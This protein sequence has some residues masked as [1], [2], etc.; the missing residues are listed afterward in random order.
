MFKHFRRGRGRLSLPLDEPALA[1]PSSRKQKKR[2]RNVK[3]LSVF[4]VAVTIMA[5]G[6]MATKSS[7]L[8]G[9][10]QS[11]WDGTV[12]Q[13]QL[14]NLSL[15]SASRNAAGARRFRVFMPA[16]APHLSLCKSVM[17]SVALGYPL[18]VLLNWKG[19]FN[20]PEWH[21]AGSHIAKLESLHA[22]IEALLA[23]P[24]GVAHDDDLAV[25]VDAY[26]VWFQLPPS[27]LIRRYHQLNREAD[28]RVRKE[29]EATWGEHT[30]FPIPPPKHNILVTAAK[31][32]H[33]GPQSGSDPHY[34]HWPKSP[35]PEFMYGP[36]TD[37][38]AGPLLDA[39]RKYK[40]VRPR[41]V[42][43]GM[44]MGTM[45][46]LRAALSRGK[47]KIAEAERTG[48]QLW[49]DQA[50]FGDVMGDQ[51]LWREWMR[52]LGSTWDGAVAESA[53]SSLHR[54]VRPIV[55]AALQGK[56]FEFGIGLDYGFATIPPTCSA[57]EDGYFVRLNDHEQVEAE[58]EKAGVVDGVRVRGVPSEL[59]APNSNAASS[60][61][62]SAARDD[63]D[64]ATYRD[65][66]RD[67]AWGDVPLYTDFFFGTTPV[68]IHHNAYVDNL[69]AWRVEHW[70]ERMW[71][72]PQ[73]RRLVSS[74][75]ILP[76]T[77]SGVRPLV[78]MPALAAD[79][80]EVVYM[81]PASETHEKVV[82]VFEPA[83][84]G[85]EATFSPISWDGI[86]QKGK[87]PWFEELFGDKI[88]PLAL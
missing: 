61:P 73:L 47:E 31:D 70:W 43:S 68:G 60:S 40:K 82:T 87:K 74:H 1:P 71:F 80:T 65:P 79:G 13:A 86:C 14:Q 50:L 49:S 4:V 57:E 29:W 38:I 34:E 48:R 2:F 22:A 35:M 16:D 67:I 11:S 28:Q 15:P 8:G 19:E 7:S 42:N 64:A 26:D 20:R 85:G 66:L 84:D 10:R 69:K 17:S 54:D 44:I 55:R 51:E 5:T 58:S 23:D 76:Q 27:V 75:L 32:C 21:L 24:R 3:R 53:P 30:N 72:Y 63:D 59:A 77:G 81:P 39:A 33:P 36:G 9:L 88:G 41:C 18:P 25:L 12:T 37:R 46:A 78:R 83:A 52:H 45:G 62:S 6:F 56:N